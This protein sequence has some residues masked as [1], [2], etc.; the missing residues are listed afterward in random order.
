M[1]LWHIMTVHELPDF[2]GT[3][4]NINYLLCKLATHA[5]QAGQ[6]KR[7]AKMGVTR[8]GVEQTSV[9]DRKGLCAGYFLALSDICI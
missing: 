7:G 3:L 6:L 5:K 8:S 2:Y 9:L 1:A 4:W